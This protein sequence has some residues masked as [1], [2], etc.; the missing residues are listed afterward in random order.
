MKKKVIGI[1]LLCTILCLAHYLSHNVSKQYIH[2]EGRVF[3]TTYNITYEIGGESLQGEYECALEKINKSLS[4]FDSTSTISLINKNINFETDSLFRIVYDEANYVSS[5]SNGAFD[6][7]VA[8]LV[9]AWGFG[10]KNKDN[11]NDSIIFELRKHIGWQKIKIENNKLV[12]SDSATMLDASA[13]AKGF[14]VDQVASV[15]EKNNVEN[16]MVE[17]GGEC[18]VKGHNARGGDWTL[19]IV[20]PD[21]DAE[22]NNNNINTVIKINKGAIATSGNYR[23][24]YYKDGQKFAH[25]INPH[26]GKPVNHNLLSA[27]IYANNCMRADAFATACMV[28]G[29]DSAKAMI[30]NE[31]GIEGFF[32]ISDSA[33]AIK[34]TQT[35]GFQSLIF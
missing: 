31:P 35:S 24:F 25:T 21:E 26:T 5:K 16:Y 15:L 32:I 3:G 11:I 12:K 13:I 7:T 9:N 22:Q 30:E 29:A 19:G 34:T 33:G 23:R 8:P 1:G 17:I 6:I 18:V 4:M 28:L 20:E 10:F 14:A 2:E 27:T